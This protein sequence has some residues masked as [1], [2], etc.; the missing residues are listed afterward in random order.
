MAD[1]M[2][3]SVFLPE[4]YTVIQMIKVN[5]KVRGCVISE[6]YLYIASYIQLY[7]FKKC[8]MILDTAECQSHF[9]WVTSAPTCTVAYN[10]TPLV[11]YIRTLYFMV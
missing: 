1:G 11:W 5:I 6:L 10:N 8:G 2:Q 7:M 9:I 4:I 3:A